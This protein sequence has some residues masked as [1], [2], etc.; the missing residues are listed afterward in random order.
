[1]Q[2][3]RMTMIEWMCLMSHD[4]ICVCELKLADSAFNRRITDN[5]MILL[6]FRKLPFKS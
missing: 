5:Y 4:I 6:S 3:D 2:K 1:M